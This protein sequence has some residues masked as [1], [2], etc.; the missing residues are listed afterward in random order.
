MSECTKLD[1][2]ATPYV[3]GALGPEERATVD[4]HLRACP[5][6]R[7]RIAAESA[8]QQ[9]MTS[10]RAAL[11]D[12][13]APAAL[14]DRCTALAGAPAAAAV[15]VTRPLVRYA[16]AAVVLLAVGVVAL[17]QLTRASTKVMA[18]ELAADHV[19][20]FMLN[21]VLGTHHE[22]HEAEA[23]LEARFAWDLE[24]PAGS[25]HAGLS[26]V[27][28]R[29]CLY[30]DGM[31]AHLMYHHHGQPVSVFM[32]PSTMR[33][34]EVVAVFGHEAAVWSTSDRTFVLLAR[35]SRAEVE[36]LARHVRATL[37]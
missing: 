30:G 33:R 15:P 27:G 6:C 12:D 4:A 29:P 25:D 36:Q 22:P 20:C 10:R 1:S 37:Q 35:E 9:L 8:V 26:L 34:E 13:R 11:C 32:L 21:A 3:D 5:P 19:K 17:Q 7:T 31:V 28:A 24:L 2:L 18:A 16:V 14:R 23:L